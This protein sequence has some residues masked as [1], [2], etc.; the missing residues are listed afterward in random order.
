VTSSFDV[1]VIGGGV[2]GAGLA[3]DLSLRG[4]SVL[5][6]EKDDWGGATS[7]ASSWLIHG[8]PRYLTFDWETTRQSC[9]D[10]GHIIRIAR[11]LVHRCVFLLPVLPHDR[12]GL[13]RLETAMEVYDRFQPLKGSHSHVR[14][15][16]AEA[17]RLEPGLSPAL[18]G[19]LTMEE[20]GLD[21]HRLVWA[22]V[23]DAQRR[24]A[25]AINHGRAV[26]FLRQGSR[27]IGVRYVRAGQALEA[28]CRMVVNAAGPWAPAVAGSAGCEVKLRPAKGIHVVF[29][30]R[31]S[32]F[33]LSGEAIDGRELLLVPH[34]PITILGTT[35]DDYYGDLD[36]IDILPDEVAYLFQGLERC[37]PAIRD[38]RP[39]RA[40]AGARPTLFASRRYEDD[41]SRRHEV[42]DHEKRDGV[43]GLVTIAGGKLSMYRLMAEKTAD[44][45]CRRLD[46][47]APC[48]TAELRLPGAEGEAPESAS[49]AH[50]YKIPELAAAHILARHGSEAPAL[51]EESD[52]T[53]HR[54]VCR[55]EALTEVELR[56]A[57]RHEQVSTLGDAFRRIGMAAGPCAGAGCLERAGAIIGQELGW[58]TEQRRQAL[59]DFQA[60]AWLGRAPLLNRWGWAQ[61]ELTYGARRGWPGR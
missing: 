31:I 60:R 43:A 54:I 26:G 16:A 25:M 20:W 45:V 13:E 46:H 29:D 19:A 34:G 33:A 41:L 51:L 32:N 5:L 61:E 3:R 52:A 57:A 40:T 39:V 42:L 21:P 48:R 2:T 11:H 8:G 38:Y 12:H 49:L 6:L 23:L 53:G 1:I 10:A 14:L 22:N 27:L 28:R 55:C 58:S 9:L 15:V 7:G 44:V 30:R 35:D 36:R 56:H 4:L 47:S 59:N 24:G 18:L 50:A 17:R 37:F